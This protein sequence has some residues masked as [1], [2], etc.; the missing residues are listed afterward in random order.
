MG[1]VN[2]TQCTELTF[3]FH[4]RLH[5]KQLREADVGVQLFLM[6]S[7]SVQRQS[8]G[9]GDSNNSS[10]LKITPLET[11]RTSPE[12]LMH[13][14]NPQSLK[15]MQKEQSRWLPTELPCNPGCSHFYSMRSSE[16]LTCQ[17]RNASAAG[18]ACREDLAAWSSSWHSAYS[19][20]FRKN[21]DCPLLIFL[22][23]GEGRQKKRSWEQVTTE[24]STS[25]SYST[26]GDWKTLKLF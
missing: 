14:L 23:S 3:L 17:T 1:E 9:S 19:D 6:A 18:W 10:Q 21:N 15:L 7:L 8:F 24:K 5:V 12:K 13:A 2:K 22:P 25:P 16:R 11:H 26:A 4:K 20:K